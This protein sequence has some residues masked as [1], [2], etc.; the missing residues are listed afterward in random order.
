MG[1]GQ[2]YYNIVYILIGCCFIRFILIVM[3]I[4]L[5]LSEIP[6][7]DF[8]NYCHERFARH[9]SWPRYVNSSQV[10]A[11]SLSTKEGIRRAAGAVVV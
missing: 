9:G 11:I 2:R 8:I 4:I 1:L 3:S 5:L 7:I 6:Q 10:G